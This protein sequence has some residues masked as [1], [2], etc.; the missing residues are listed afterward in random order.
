M[1]N[2]TFLFSFSKWSFYLAINQKGNK[3][4]A[5]FWNLT[6]KSI[7]KIDKMAFLKYN[8]IVFP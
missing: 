2:R 1:C 3:N 8:L 6:A 4:Y 5:F 7:K